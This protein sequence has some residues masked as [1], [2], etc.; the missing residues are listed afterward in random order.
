MAYELMSSQVQVVLNKGLLIR[1]HTV[2]YLS[3]MHSDIVLAIIVPS[4]T[5][6]NKQYSKAIYTIWNSCKFI[7]EFVKVQDERMPF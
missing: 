4:C 1:G 2:H 3:Q 6:D 5:R 7:F